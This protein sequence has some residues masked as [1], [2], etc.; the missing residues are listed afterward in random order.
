MKRDDI[1]YAALHEFTLHDYEGASINTIIE[2]SGTSKGTFYHHFR[3]KEAL[4]LELV[5]RVAEEKMRFMQNLAAASPAQS[6][7]GSIFD[8]LRSQIATA[9]RFSAAHPEYARFS[10]RV[11]KESK[12]SIREKLDALIGGKTQELFGQMIRTNIAE[13]HLRADLSEKFV[14]HMFLFMISRFNEFLL[15]M[16][17]PIE[18]E[19]MDRIMVILGEYIEFLEKGLGSRT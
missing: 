15:D 1:I 8:L 19:H 10:T 2:Q 18:V 13:K 5:Q 11:A 9:V 16:D 4:Y 6:T 17:M 7:K 14:T 12:R 3:S